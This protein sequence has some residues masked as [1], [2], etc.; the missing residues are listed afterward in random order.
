[1]L[2]SQ[3]LHR[4]LQ[5]QAKFRKAFRLLIGLTCKLMPRLMLNTTKVKESH[6]TNQIKHF[7]IFIKSLQ[8]LIVT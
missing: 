4:S 3:V 2:D 7:N 6:R 8:F 1:M 5:L